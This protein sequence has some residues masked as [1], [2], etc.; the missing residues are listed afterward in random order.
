[1]KIFQA[2]SFRRISSM[3]LGLAVISL[4]SYAVAAEK[5]D[6][7]D[8]AM[9]RRLQQMQQVQQ[10]AEQENADLKEQL[11]E[12]GTKLTA[13]QAELSRQKKQQG[14]LELQNS[15]Q[16]A[17]QTAKISA[18]Q[19]AQQTTLNELEI[20]VAGVKQ[21]REEKS[22]LEAS[23]SAQKNEVSSC[24]EKNLKLKND[25]Q[26]MI[27]KYEKQA[28]SGVEPLTGLKGVEIENSFQDYRDQVENQHYM[29]RKGP[30]ER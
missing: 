17:Q 24:Q 26:E 15:D 25:A 9:Q 22:R 8:R 3:L 21:L 12:L 28:L 7:Q 23:L 1:M 14:K 20:N 13:V 11:K 29:P 4:P 5:S 16:T 27:K 19:S 18:C 30:S 10:K 2:N 6:K